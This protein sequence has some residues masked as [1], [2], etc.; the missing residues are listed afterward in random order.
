VIGTDLSPIQPSWVPPNCKFEIDNCELPW[1]YPDNTF[2]YIHIRGLVGCIRDWENLYGE[3]LRCLKPGGWL[4]QQEFALPIASEDGSLPDGCVW[5]DWGDIFRD[6]GRKMG[7]TFEVTNDWE[8]WMKKA[9]FSGS[10]HT[11]SVKLPIGDWPLDR[12]WKEVGMF[13][14]LSLEQGLE[15]FATYICTQVLGW[16]TVETALLLAKVRQA[17]KNKSY[18]AYYPL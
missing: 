2:D 13:N 6:A 9:G 8:D 12:K 4:E 16:Q 17:I 7:Q 10:I 5:H 3:C 15:G 1:T 11:D 18:R 14:R